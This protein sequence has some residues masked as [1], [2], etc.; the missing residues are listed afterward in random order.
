PP[1]LTN[2]GALQY[3]PLF[4]LYP[5]VILLSRCRP[6]LLEV[7]LTGAWLLL[8]LKGFRYVPLWVLMAVPVM[9]R[10]S[11]GIPWVAAFV[12]RHLSSTDPSSLFVRREGPV[13][14]GVWSVVFA[15]LLVGGSPLLKDRFAKLLPQVVATDA[16]DQLVDLHKEEAP[17]AVVFHSYNW[18]GYLTWQ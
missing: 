11:Y 4:V 5:V 3:V 15:V 14:W 18:G 13:P 10:A 16:L 1:P 7:G 12:D 17:D 2:A 8:A 6:T 9:A